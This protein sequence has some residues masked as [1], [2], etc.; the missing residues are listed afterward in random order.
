MTQPP[1]GRPMVPEDLFR[2]RFVSDPQL[3]PDARRVAFVVTTLSEARDEYLSTIWVVDV[4]GG[5]AR[6]FT[7]GPR[8]DTAPRWSPDGR[9]LAFV[10]EREKKGKGQLHVM[11]ADGGEPVRLTDLRP[12]VASPAWS[13]DGRLAR[14]RLAGRRVGGADGR[15]GARA[16]QAAPDHRRAQV[17]VE[18]R[19]LRLRPARAGLR[20]LRGRRVRP[21]SSRPARSTV[22]IRRGRP[23]ASTWRSC[24]PATPDRDEDGAADVFTVPVGGG[25]ARRLTRTEGPVSWPAFSPDGR[26]VAYVGHTDARGVS[27]HHRLYVV[28][29]DGGAPVCLTAR[30]DRNCE[31]TDGR[32][33]PAVARADG[34]APV[35]GGGRGRRATSTGSRRRAAALRSGSS[36]APAR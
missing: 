10:S 31:P 6:P 14:L 21:A 24:P 22:T 29:A 7:R 26:A 33:E 2:I 32:G 36:A 28:P 5:D 30:F 35:P 34:R 18:R 25:E 11:P 23:T 19:G 1:P 20:G 8:R 12:G 27:R 17:Q 3:H 13:P 4:D 16:L 9:W 15:G